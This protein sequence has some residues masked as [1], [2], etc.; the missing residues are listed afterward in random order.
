MVANPESGQSEEAETRSHRPSAIHLQHHV[1]M[2]PAKL[3]SQQES[4]EVGSMTAE[5]AQ[6]RSQQQPLPCLAPM[7]QANLGSQREKP[8]GESMMGETALGRSQQQQ[9]PWKRPAPCSKCVLQTH[10]F[11]PT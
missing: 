6:G 2:R 9:P 8:E 3:G 1:L 11:A 4:C 7:R 10:P 5:V